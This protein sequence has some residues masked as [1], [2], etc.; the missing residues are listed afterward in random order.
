LHRE[1]PEHHR[2][3]HPRIAAVLERLDL[4]ERNRDELASFHILD[5]D[6]LLIRAEAR[7][8]AD[9]VAPLLI[10]HAIGNLDLAAKGHAT[11]N[12]KLAGRTTSPRS[13]TSSCCPG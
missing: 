3:S 10:A 13:I 5:E 2:E 12:P 1:A 8:P 7:E 11:R 6:V 4:H 9:D